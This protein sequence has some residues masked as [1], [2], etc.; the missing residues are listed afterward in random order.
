M[1]RTRQ[2]VTSKL[3]ALVVAAGAVAAPGRAFAAGP[4]GNFTPPKP[5]AASYG[6]DPG[7]KC[8]VS[9]LRDVL[10][11]LGEAAKQAHRPA[12]QADGRLCAVAEALLAWPAGATPRPEVL[13]FLSQW[14]GL[15]D[16]V[17]TP[18]I[19]EFDMPDQREIATRVAQSGAGTAAL[20]AARPLVGMAVQKSRRGRYDTNTKIAI[21]VLDSPIEIQPVP[22]VLAKG[23]RAMLSGKVLAGA[24]RPRA[25]AA[26]PTGK[27]SSA[28]PQSG[29]S[30]ELP[31][32]CGDRAG[33]ILV[34]VRAD[35]NGG[36]A[37]VASFS[38]A[39]GEEPSKAVAVAGETWPTDSAAAERKI[40]D[41]INAE[42]AT[43]GV[44]P[45]KWDDAIG[46]VARSISEELAAS[47]GVPG[48]AGLV[49]R[50]KKE[51]IGSPLV[52]ES[53]AAERTYERAQDRLA[54]SPRDRATIL[55]PEAS[56]AGV[57]AV[58]AKDSQGRPIVYVTEILIKEL[59][60]L[61][62]AKVRQQLRDEIERKRRDARIDP[63]KP[64]PTL[65]EVAEKFAQALA[66]AGGALSKEQASELTAPLNRS[67][68]SVTMLSGAKQEPLDFAEEPQT[69]VPGKALG[70][71]VAQG[72]HPVL[73]RNAV[74][75]TIM[76]GTPR[77][78]SEEASATP[79]KKKKAAAPAKK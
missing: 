26:D 34:E 76:V 37:Q 75:V 60:P 24:T 73:G 10:S 47:R 33:R 74:Y 59:P 19:A 23:Q 11:D 44:P 38:V 3:A 49:E 50:L 22:R 25:Y 78:A 52:L 17:G 68:K 79:A 7:R 13:A 35:V 31:L 70:V 45:V 1:P 64:H 51:G 36:V 62:V 41:E 66:A 63:L 15:P 54:N 28:E 56:L 30:F 42:R 12:A 29:D 8:E 46:R 48:S 18:V 77:G 14:Y 61:D 16:S 57:G 65:D 40:L 69:T 5:P 39:C 55:N 72:R 20:N 21:V 4:E 53:A 6:T 9:M 71:G 27:V 2:L 67:F 43:A 32:E 58:A